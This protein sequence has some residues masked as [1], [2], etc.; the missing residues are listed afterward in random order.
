MRPAIALVASF[1]MLLHVAGAFA[2]TTLDDTIAA[3][4]ERGQP[5]PD[6]PDDLD[7]AAAYTIQA[8]V[9]ER[10]YAKQIAGYKAGLTSVAAQQRFGVDQPVLGV[11]PLSGQ[12]PPDSTIVLVPGLKIEVE[13]GF[14][15]GIDGEP[16]EMLASIELP[17][18]AYADMQ[19]VSFADIVATNVAAYRFIA[20][21]SAKLDPN[22]RAYPVS[23]DYDGVRLFTASAADALGD[24]FA[25]Y[26]WM[27]ARI[28][29]LGYRL[30][31]GMVLI[32]GSLGRV[33]D[34]K[35]GEYVARYGALGELKFKIDGDPHALQNT[36]PPPID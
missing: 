4:T 17:R 22:V 34:A 9:V 3:A 33:V 6:V 31:P 18:L 5:F 35:P 13:I 11:L 36:S 20:G 27:V 12:L 30:D 10:I 15:V 1:V 16:G 19:Q 14:V 24:P 23:L 2:A 25:A 26:R 28:R 7:A 21:H 8:E 29:A 32:T